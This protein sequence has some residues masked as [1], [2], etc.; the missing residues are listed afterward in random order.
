M[1]KISIVIALITSLFSINT[2]AETLKLTNGE[3]PPFLSKDLNHYGVASHI[4][5]EAFKNKGDDV[6]YGFFPWKRAFS[7][8]KDGDDW[9]G[10]VIWSHSEEREADFL[11]SAPVIISKQ[12]FFYR[13]D[14][15]FDWNTYDDLGNYKI[16]AAIG[17]FYGEE[18]QQAESSGLITVERTSIESSNFKKL[19]ASRIDVVIAERDTGYEIMKQVLTAE[20]I[21]SLDISQ[22][23]VA[24]FTN[25]LVISKKIENGEVLLS[26][27]NKGLKKLIKSGKVEQYLMESRSGLYHK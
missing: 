25:H 20:Q 6:K 22:K 10:S 7:N 17:Y 21:E 19:A 2:F 13:K 8:A 12:V 15:E 14:L 11:Y 18:F 16:G 4:V 27:F 9:V 26:T 23:E 1:K 3:W 5:E 24:S